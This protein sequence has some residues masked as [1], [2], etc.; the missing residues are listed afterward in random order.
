MNRT[1]PA[2]IRRKLRK[3]AGFTC[4]VRECS[5]PYLSY[6][7]FDP[8]WAEQ[9]HHNVEGMIALCLQHHKEADSGA[10]T[11]DQL[12]QLKSQRKNSRLV[13]GDINWK[14]ENLL[15]IA[16][17]NIYVGSPTI[18]E[19][20]SQKF[21]WFG[22]NKDGYITINLD[23][24]CSQGRLVFSM[25]DNDWCTI[26]NLDDL[27]CPLGARRR[28]KVRS[29]IHDISLDLKFSKIRYQVLGDFF[30]KLF[31]PTKKERSKAFEYPD[32]LGDIFGLPRIDPDEEVKRRSNDVK[33][34]V[35]RKLGYK[36]I[37][38]CEVNLKIT[39]PVKL[40]LT[41]AKLE[42]DGR[43]RFSRCFMGDKTVCRIP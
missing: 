21:L 32:P 29:K 33:E 2:T 17:S 9:E 27:D 6:H 10:F 12:K 20:S 11:K 3:E 25:R 14:R 23:L 35:G 43:I 22:R 19:S 42:I 13:K 30:V 28:L 8:P 26:P 40:H 41:P 37:S 31:S 15:I 1:P 34:K 7:H 18:L 36:S 38:I 16:G 4:P 5:S 39:Y 24:F